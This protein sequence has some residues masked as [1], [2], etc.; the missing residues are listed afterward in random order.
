[1]A[2]DNF[3][4]AVIEK[5]RTRVA[6]RCSNPNC[7]VPTTGPSCNKVKATIIGVAA[8]ITA[9][10]VGGP[11]YDSSLTE[12]A[13]KSMD[14]GIWLCNNCSVLIDRDIGSYSV[15]LLNQ[16]K[17]EAE[18]NAKQEL[19]QKLPH[20]NDAV[21]TLTTALTGQSNKLIPNAISNVHKAST[22]VLEALDPRFAV[23]S[24]FSEGT[25]QFGIFAKQDVSVSMN[26]KKE[27]AQEYTDK[28][29]QLVEHGLDLTISGS[30]ISFEGSKLLEEISANLANGTFK[31][32]PQKNIATQKI[33]LVN[34]NTS[35]TE[36]FDDIHGEIA[37]GRKTV[38]FAGTACNDLF[39][40]K[41][42]LGTKTESNIATVN[43][44]IGFLKWSGLDVRSLPYFNKIY[45]LYE[46]LSTGWDFVT[47]LE[48]DGS[49]IFRSKE[50]TI[51]DND[52]LENTFQVLRIIDDARILARSTNIRITF[53][54]NFSFTDNEYCDFQNAVRAADGKF[55]LGKAD[56]AGNIS[57]NLIV[58]KEQGN[59]DR[60]QQCTEP[61]NIE[62][63]E[64]DRSA[65]RIFGQN[66]LLPNKIWHIHAVRPLLSTAVNEELPH[67]S[68]INIEWIPADGFEARLEFEKARE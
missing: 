59:L 65:L 17:I 49:E 22:N 25:T 21:D 6:N 42:Q 20:K 7:R 5:L 8:H 63:V 24:T 9:A 44:T 10:A 19:G 15:E 3:T 33:W 40:F 4:Q 31:L 41:Y 48:I 18:K 29:A 57:T 53:D 36:S 13:R 38:S 64:T 35:I 50:L 55:V 16:W 45:S 68:L 46:K 47:A 61:M 62:Y 54:P 67:G 1:M 34:R 30:A 32:S 12:K 37:H 66:I 51:D 43:A 56:L 14:N 58:D 26:I 11:R 52:L 39:T 28:F 23:K 27:Y 2:R 60:I